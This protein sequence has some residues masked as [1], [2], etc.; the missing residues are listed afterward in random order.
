M[1]V[2]VSIDLERTEQPRGRKV[3]INIRSTGDQHQVRRSDTTITVDL[4]LVLGT[5]VTIKQCRPIGY[6]N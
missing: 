1:G 3:E 4:P 5:R 6:N 2:A